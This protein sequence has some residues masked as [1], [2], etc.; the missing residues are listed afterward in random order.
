MGEIPTVQERFQAILK[1]RLQDQIAENPPL[2][3]W[4]TQVV[5]YPE[6]I[7]GQLMGL[8][9]VWGWT[10]HQSKLSLPI[11][12]PEQVFRQLLEKCQV[13]LTSS[14]PLGAKLV[15]VVES[16]FPTDTQVINDLAGLVLRSS[17]RSADTLTATPDVESDYFD[18]LPRQ[19]MALSLMAAKQLLE[20]L[21]LP[22]SFT[23]PLLERQ[24]LTSVGTLSIRVEL[25]NLGKSTKLIV[26]GEL[27]T[28]G[29]LQVQSHYTQD[30][31][32][33]DTSEI[34]VIELQIDRNQPNYTLAVEFPELDQQPLL[35]AIQVKI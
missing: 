16:M 19:Q 18:L 4:E 7:E 25:R 30:C 8:V 21:I 12:L 14:L 28:P 22:I 10:A 34:P 32:K 9:P 35:L 31:I 20:N 17:Y 24:W 26:Q 29:I 33:S 11:S 13:L 3:P 15:Q 6:S 2:F 23:Q 5:D 27:P 1:R